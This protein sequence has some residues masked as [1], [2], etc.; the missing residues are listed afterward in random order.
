MTDERAKRLLYAESHHFSPDHINVLV[1]NATS[2]PGGI[3]T[4]TPLIRCA[5]QPTQNRR[6][7]AI[8]LFSVGIGGEKMGTLETWT[9]ITNSHAYCPIPE[10]FLQRVVNEEIEESPPAI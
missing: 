1:I 3:K 5:L 8:I 7:S 6:F 10:K 4:W 2:V 9:A